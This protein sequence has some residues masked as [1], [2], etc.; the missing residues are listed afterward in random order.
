MEPEKYMTIERSPVSSLKTCIPPWAFS[1]LKINENLFLTFRMTSDTLL[2]GFWD[3]CRMRFFLNIQEKRK[4][5]EK[6]LRN[7][8]SFNDY[9]VC[10]EV[11]VRWQKARCTAGG[12]PTLS[13]QCQ[14]HCQTNTEFCVAHGTEFTSTSLCDACW[15]VYCSKRP[16][17]FCILSVTQV[18]PLEKR[19][20]I[21]VGEDKLHSCVWCFIHEKWL[22]KCNQGVF[23]PV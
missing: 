6:K 13:R 10:S 9:R 1:R 5:R 22:S 16:R 3:D 20:G 19:E 23:N 17:I 21:I 8:T 11:M 7:S 15:C 12:I 18:L 2:N 14:R 4:H